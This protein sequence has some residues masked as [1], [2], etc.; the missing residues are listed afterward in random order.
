MKKAV[1][2]EQALMWHM[3]ASPPSDIVCNCAI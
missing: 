2:K 3:C 1:E